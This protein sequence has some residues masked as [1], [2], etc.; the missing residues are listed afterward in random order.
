MMD[1]LLQNIANIGFPIA[2]SAYLLVRL[3]SKMEELKTS[4]IN[5]TKAVE[6]FSVKRG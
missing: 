6:E 1:E 3:E 2:L 5:L 4:I